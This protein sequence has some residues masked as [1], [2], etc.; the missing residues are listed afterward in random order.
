MA[1][2]LISVCLLVVVVVLACF[3][4]EEQAL[5]MS[6]KQAMSFKKYTQAEK[7]RAMKHIIQKTFDTLMSR[8]QGHKKATKTSGCK[9]A[10]FEDCLAITADLPLISADMNIDDQMSFC[11][12]VV[13]TLGQCVKGELENIGGCVEDSEQLQ[14]VEDGLS[15]ISVLTYLCINDT[16]QVIVDNFDCVENVLND[17]TCFNV[18]DERE[19]SKFGKRQGEGDESDTPEENADDCTLIQQFLEC[20]ANDAATSCGE[21]AQVEKIVEDLVK[22]FAAPYLGS[23]PDQCNID[24]D[25]IVRAAKFQRAQHKEDEKKSQLLDLIEKLGLSKKKPF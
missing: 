10:G 16:L 11:N 5:K 24:T 17:Q 19:R 3:V 21:N 4:A 14:I 12:T 20:Y 7:S 25:L 15:A 23:V 9:I 13:V 2:G 8:H 6:L 18:V 1:S 22:I